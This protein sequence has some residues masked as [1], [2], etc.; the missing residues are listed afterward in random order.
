MSLFQRADWLGEG[1]VQRGIC[2]PG[3]FLVQISIQNTDTQPYADGSR[4]APV[5]ATPT[6]CRAST[7]SILRRQKFQAGVEVYP[8]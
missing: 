7:V 5:V 3:A 2:L 1:L 6:V 8:A 4:D